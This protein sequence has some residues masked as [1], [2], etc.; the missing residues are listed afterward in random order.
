MGGWLYSIFVTF[1]TLVLTLTPVFAAERRLALVIG[2]KNYQHFKPLEN[3]I[4]DAEL[5][6]DRLRATGF[7]VDF[8]KDPSR[9]LLRRAVLDF[10]RTIEAAGPDAVAL[11]YY[12]G[13]G[14]Q[15]SKLANFLIGA[16]A[17]I[18]SLA[19]LPIEA[20]KFDDVLQAIEAAKP[21]L[22]FAILDACR[23]NPMPETRMR[24]DKRGLAPESNLPRDLLIAFSTEPGKAADDGPPGGHSPF[25]SALAEKLDTPGLEAGELFRQVSLKVHSVTKAEQF[26]WVSE[27]RTRNF[28]FRPGGVGGNINPEPLGGSGQSLPPANSTDNGNL[29]YGA[30]VS[31]NTVKGY[32]AW[33]A[34]Y[35]SHPRRPDVL[36]LLQSL[37][38][39]ELWKNAEAASSVQDRESILRRLMQAY[40]RGVYAER[41]RQL[42]ARLEPE[43]PPVPRPSPNPPKLPGTY[44][45]VTGLD[46]GGWNWL[47]LRNAPEVSAEWSKTIQ[48]GPDTPLTVIG[49]SGDFTKVRLRSGETGWVTALHV[50]CCRQASEPMYSF[51]AGV[52]LTCSDGWLALRSGPSTT[53]AFPQEPKLKPGALMAV[54]GRSGDFSQVRLRSGETGWVSSRFIRCCR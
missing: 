14:I 44:Q 33:L 13:H 8:V 25:A 40:P 49:Q 50:G 10:G 36:A 28:Y 45:Y 4:A 35:A 5:I 21:R 6:A 20:L 2:I 19:D 1:W 26:P 17:E 7:A 18:K 12:A 29:D 43:P 3:T 31:T 47:A 30:A 9:D 15:D 22:A 42:L 16:D 53:A 54:I 37:R 24:G 23:D 34:K 27:R 46:P 52:C 39:E 11:I 41:A 48:I 51:V 32:E 38:A